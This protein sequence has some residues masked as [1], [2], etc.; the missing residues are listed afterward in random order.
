MGFIAS[1]IIISAR[2]CMFGLVSDLSSKNC[3]P[4]ELNRYSS[5]FFFG[6]FS[7]LITLRPTYCFEIL[8]IEL[9]QIELRSRHLFKTTI[10]YSVCL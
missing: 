2:T 7:T 10:G 5:S 1:I 8:F 9:N 3:Y 6:N 4:L